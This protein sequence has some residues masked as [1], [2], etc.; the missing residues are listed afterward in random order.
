MRKCAVVL[1]DDTKLGGIVAVVDDGAALQRD[2]V[3]VN[4]RP[5]WS[6]I[7]EQLQSPTCR[8]S[9]LQ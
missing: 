8:R 6:F 2:F 3:T 9:T 4:T 1:A 5:I 7:Q